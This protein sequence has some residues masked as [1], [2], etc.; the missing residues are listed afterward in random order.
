MRA[1]LPDLSRRSREAWP[2]ISTRAE[3]ASPAPQ[4]TMRT[5][6]SWRPRASGSAP[7]ARRRGSRC[8]HRAHASAMAGSPPGCAALAAA[9]WSRR[10]RTPVSWPASH[11]ARRQ[12]AAPRAA[13]RGSAGPGKAVRAWTRMTSAQRQARQSQERSNAG[14][15]ALRLQPRAPHA[16]A[17]RS[18]ATQSAWARLHA[19]SR[20]C[21]T[22]AEERHCGSARTA[23]LARAQRRTPSAPAPGAVSTA[24]AATRGAPAASSHWSAATEPLAAAAST[25]RASWTGYASPPAS[26][27]SRIQS[28]T[29][30]APAVALTSHSV[31][32]DALHPRASAQASTS[33]LSL[34]AATRGARARHESGASRAQSW[35]TETEVTLARSEAGCWRSQRLCTQA[36]RWHVRRASAQWASPTAKA[37]SLRQ[38]TSSH[39]KGQDCAV[40]MASSEGRRT[41]GVV[42]CTRTLSRL[43]WLEGLSADASD[44]LEGAS[45]SRRDAR[46][47]RGESE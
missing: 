42:P 36:R 29:R 28:S 33:G 44:G 19:V 38:S 14:R 45:R 46:R 32:G 22:A 9:P 31:R 5:V 10:R 20:A 37:T 8:G 41:G 27:R 2:R 35:A 40:R 18:A 11:A 34:R 39:A 47:R 24:I 6:R 21:A 17:S 23:G 13:A 15:S 1:V 30:T 7:A 12:S 16:P 26:A 43:L 4:A 3:A 25:T